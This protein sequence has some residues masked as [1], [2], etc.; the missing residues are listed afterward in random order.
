MLLI[1]TR[2]VSLQMLL[3]FDG[4]LQSTYGNRYD[5]PHKY[6]PNKSDQDTNK[7]SNS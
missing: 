5:Q 1:M 7:P 3:L 4:K 2:F 6:N